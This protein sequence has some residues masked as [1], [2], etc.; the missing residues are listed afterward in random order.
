M[1][2]WLPQFRDVGLIGGILQPPYVR[3]RGALMGPGTF[4][5][6][7]IR[8]L[9]AISTPSARCQGVVL[10]TRHEWGICDPASFD[11]GNRRSA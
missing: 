3:Y 1:V 9:E 7:P 8:W 5:L 2:S 4:V 11:A 6:N 10:L